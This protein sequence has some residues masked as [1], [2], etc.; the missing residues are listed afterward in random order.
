MVDSIAR[1]NPMIERIINFFPRHLPKNLLISPIPYRTHTANVPISFGSAKVIF[2]K[3]CGSQ[4]IPMIIVIV[5]NT[6]PI[7]AAMKL[8]RS[9]IS[10][11]GKRLNIK[12]FL[13]LLLLLLDL[14]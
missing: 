2:G 3:A 9:N 11:L 6:N 7:I 13:K 5:N 10:K 14:E 4:I 12:P 8:I 1:Q